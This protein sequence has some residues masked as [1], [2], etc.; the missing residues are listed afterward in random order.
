M[1]DL[2]NPPR[3]RRPWD[4]LYGQTL[5]QV[6]EAER[7]GAS[8]VW[9]SE[10]HFFEDGYLSQPLTFASALAARTKK[11]RIG[12]AVLLAPLRTPLQIAEE[13]AVVD[14]VSGGRLDLG[15]GAGYRQ[16]EFAAFGADLGSRFA[17]LRQRV[18]EVRDLLASGRVTPPPI[19]DPLPIWFGAGAAK[20][21]RYA[22]RMGLPLLNVW[23]E[24]AGPY[25][26]GLRE[27]G[28]P[29]DTGRMAGLLNLLIADDPEEAWVRARPHIEYQWN[30][31]ASYGVEGL[32]VDPPP[33]IDAEAMRQPRADGCPPF[34][35]A[36]TP[37]QA[38]P[39]IGEL[40]RH[41]P[42]ESVFFWAS[43]AGMPDDLARRHVEL[44]CTKLRSALEQIG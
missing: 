20:A 33:P 42:V 29:P 28:H 18:R 1:V 44:V 8:S 41:G 36:F 15:L 9:T 14:L 39:M 30:S 38:A 21:A 6:E 7:L 40:A 5:E 32:G 16:P 27:G 22:G 35:G 17:T 26:E 3:W 2:R 25:L 24:V 13:A 43:M 4:R 23:S 12:T 10:H 31:Y 37:E 11:M 34:L 19:Q